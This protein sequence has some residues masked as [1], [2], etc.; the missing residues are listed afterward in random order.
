M[1]TEIGAKKFILAPKKLKSTHPKGFQKDHENHIMKQICMNFKII[2]TAINIFNSFF[3]ELEHP[4]IKLDT[5]SFLFFRPI[6]LLAVE[7][8]LRVMNKTYN[9]RS[10]CFLIFLFCWVQHSEV[11]RYCQTPK[12]RYCM[13]LTQNVSSTL[14]EDGGGWYVDDEGPCILSGQNQLPI[15][16]SSKFHPHFWYQ[17]IVLVMVLLA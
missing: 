4:P 11:S 8:Y 9:P 15:L 10:F 3:H 7:N 6:G 2:G 5:V 16:I 13:T 14:A 1:F 12:I 17:F